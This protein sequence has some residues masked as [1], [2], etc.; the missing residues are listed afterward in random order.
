MFSFRPLRVSNSEELVFVHV[1][2][3]HKLHK[4]QLIESS[5]SELKKAGSRHS[6]VQ[7]LH[8]TGVNLDFVLSCAFFGLE[9][10]GEDTG[11]FL[12]VLSATFLGGI[13]LGVDS[14]SDV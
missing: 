5:S 14:V 8:L 10:L 13:V 9:G 12:S 1:L 7:T 2:W 11:V 3:Y 4:S 6:F